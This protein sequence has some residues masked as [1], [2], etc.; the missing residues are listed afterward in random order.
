MTDIPDAQESESEDAVMAGDP[1]PTIIGLGASAGGLEAFSELLRALPDTTG[2]AFVIVQHLSPDHESMLPELLQEAASISVKQAVD[3]T[4]PEA[5]HAYVIPPDVMMTL[6]SDRLSLQQRMHDGQRNLPVD[7]FFQSL[8]EA[9][10]NRAV[11]VVLS[12]TG[13]D[14]TAGLLDIR[15]AGGV[16]IAQSPE[17]ARY[18]GM[19]RSAVA[20]NVVDLVLGPEEIAQELVRIGGHPYLA[21]VASS[22]APPLTNDE[23]RVKRI[24]QLLQRHTGVDFSGY[25]PGTFTRRMYRR[26]MLQ[27]LESVDRYLHY[28]EENP[29]EIQRL[30]EDI[31]IHVTQFFRS[32]KMFEALRD[33]VL[34]KMLDSRPSEKPL[35][36]W[37]PGCA[38]GEE[39]YSIAIVLLEYLGEQSVEAPI[40]IF[41]TDI[42]D[43]S[44]ERA[45]SGTYGKDIVADVSPERLQRWFTQTDSGYR[46]NRAV[47]EL[48][49]FS[50]QDLTRD[51][52]FSQIDLLVCRNVLIYMGADL[53]QRLLRL[54]HYALKSDGFLILGESETV[55]QQKPELFSAVDRKC[56]IY[57]PRQVALRVHDVF[58]APTPEFHRRQQPAHGAPPGGARNSSQQE[59][60]QYIIQRYSPPSAVVDDNHRILFVRG[61]TGAWLEAPQ[62]EPDNDL[63]RM[64]RPGLLGGLR[65]ALAEV[66]DTGK[67]ARREQLHTLAD[68]Q[69][70]EVNID[71]VPLGSKVNGRTYLVLFEP[72]NSALAPDTKPHAHARHPSDLPALDA[73]EKD[74]RI[75]ELEVELDATRDQIETITQDYES[76][77][78]ELQTASEEVLSSNEELQST[79]EEL[80][81]AHEE[82]QA[83]NEELNSLNDELHT[84]NDELR[85]ANDDLMNLLASVDVGIVMVDKELRIRR[86]TPVGAALMNLIDADI[87]R[88]ITHINPSV[89]VDDL[90]TGIGR[91]IR[92][93]APLA[94]E[95]EDRKGNCYSLRIRPYR[96]AEQ[97]IEGA[98]LSLYDI[99]DLKAQKWAREYAEA[100][101]ETLHEPVLVLDTELRIRTLNRAFRQLFAVDSAQTSGQY[102]QDIGDRQWDIDSLQTA[103][104]GVITGGG[105]LEGY[106]VETWFPTLGRRIMRLNARQLG[107]ADDREA[108]ILLA[109][110]DVTD[111]GDDAG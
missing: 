99:T 98:V 106:D 46:V 88:S 20:A 55:D 38:S 73:D 66:R 53:Q 28:L 82:L 65:A 109:F 32:P 71:V 11:G 31:L 84:R 87:G 18:D 21:P 48:C 68:G 39:A 27:R 37:V 36:I 90:E 103:L 76:S 60:E 17:T 35:R 12:G 110:E 59:A 34:P 111:H 10:G 41:A 92:D 105:M 49:V 22:E 29:E 75:H 67:R 42:A 96:D 33:Q 79:N 108:M 104:Q 26:M 43:S 50:R 45:R 15:A 101:I 93:N 40:Q 72:T 44:I 107:A 81:T 30:Y 52:P 100:I 7:A 2:L 62:G 102:L 19:P 95:V 80:D 61:S 47:R 86:F 85:R 64:A 89:I 94:D 25:K 1:G 57:A 14:G 23:E 9:R 8:A 6:E 24:T 4:V 58:P 97:H 77:N 83:T 91:V 16:T 54:F 63:L 56:R 69:R 13:S 70:Q 74:R 78:E 5:D 51:P 3:G